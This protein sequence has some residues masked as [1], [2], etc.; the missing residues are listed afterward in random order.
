MKINHLLAFLITLSKI[1]TQM[2]GTKFLLT[3]SL[4]GKFNLIA[5]FII[6]IIFFEHYHDVPV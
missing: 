3:L 2:I 6:I 4:S 1:S 5:F